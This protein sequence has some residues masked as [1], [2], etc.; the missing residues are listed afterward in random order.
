MSL[1]IASEPLVA[2]SARDTVVRLQDISV[3]Y[4]VPQER[5][6]SL[7]E[8]VIRRTQHRIHH[9]EFWALRDV[10]IEVKQGEVLGIIGRNGAGKSTLL[11]V[12]S[13]VMRPTQGNVWVR[14]RVAPLLELGAGFHPE[15]TGRENVLLNG[16]LLG[17]TRRQV[18]DRFDSIVDFA[19]IWDFIDAPLRTY[20]TGM[21]ARLGFAVATAWV[22]DI[23]I[24][25]EILSVGDA[26]FQMK[27]AERIQQMRGEGATVL[28]VSHNPEAIQTN[29]D[30]AVWIDQ[31]RVV[32]AGTSD[33]VARQYRGETIAVESKRLADSA[34]TEEPSKRWGTRAIEITHVRI[35]NGQGA[36]QT[37]FRTGEQLVLEMQYEAHRPI[38]APIFGMAIHHH[39]GTHITG[40][41][42]SF[43][44][45]TLPTLAGT[46]TVKYAVP[47]LNLLEGLYH[48]TVA[49]VNHDDTEMFDYHDRNYSFRVANEGGDI[50]ERQGLITLRGEW[51]HRGD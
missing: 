17:Y 13:R 37:I 24:L 49:V 28:M 22:P 20:S 43:A 31:G 3:R 47:S 34:K 19:E 16:T 48:I 46:G 2:S 40:P 7:K 45:L 12:I 9:R 18:Q 1:L 29:C 6:R 5:I 36:E 15:L 14:G 42:T 27:S 10:N 4:A 39:D 21:T 26:A 44:G 32:V 11:K 8:Y 50:L 25:D 30:Q 33:M 41:N 35:L 38:S 51:K 23:L